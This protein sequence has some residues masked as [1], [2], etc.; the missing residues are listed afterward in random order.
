MQTWHIITG[1]YPSGGVGEHTRRVAAA[2][3]RAGDEVH[4]WAPRPV[5]GFPKDSGVLVHGLP[6]R[7]GP[8][9]LL[10]LDRA[11]A[12]ASKSQILVQYV[13]HAFGFKAM[14]LPFCCWLFAR[15]RHKIFVMF[16]E[17]ACGTAS[18]AFRHNVLE[19]VTKLMAAIASRAASRIFVSTTS[20]ERMFAP[21]E[22]R[23]LPIEALPVPST[24]EVVNDREGIRKIR[25]RYGPAECFL[26]G[27][28]SAYPQ[29]VQPYLMATIPALL[30][31]KRIGVM[32]IGRGSSEFQQR[33]ASQCDGMMS[34]LHA[35]GEI[36]SYDVS[37]HLSACDLMIQPYPD[38]ITTRRSSAMAAIAHRLPVVTTNGEL[39]EPVWAENVAV[40]LV[41]ANDTESFVSTA[42]RLLDDVDE[43]KRLSAAAAK[44]YYD[45]FDVPHTVNTLRR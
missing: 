20:W 16:H 28:F 45:R 30:A 44:L 34:R 32:L 2:L 38:G 24:V 12:A 27:H 15:R 4:V 31:D 26:V 29:N 25:A 21:A 42:S 18:P 39:T 41:S 5:A 43:R 33:L 13:P 8:R 11:I 36:E 9:A 37:L 35:T 7:F 19:A 14:N 40:S 3:A 17:V 22:N 23:R 6:G 10:V 1:E